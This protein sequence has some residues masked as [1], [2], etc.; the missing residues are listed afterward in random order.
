M[1][2]YWVLFTLISSLFAAGCNNIENS[3]I[4]GKDGSVTSTIEEEQQ[5]TVNEE[6]VAVDD[7]WK[8]NIA[9]TALF[10]GCGSI[11]VYAADGTPMTLTLNDASMID[12]SKL[13][14]L[15]GK[16]V[17][18][19]PFIGDD[20]VLE[21]IAFYTA[22]GELIAQGTPNSVMDKLLKERDAELGEMLDNAVRIEGTVKMSDL[23]CDDTCYVL[24]DVVAV[25][26]VNDTGDYY[27]VKEISRG[28]TSINVQ[29]EYS[30]PTALDGQCGQYDIGP[31]W[32]T[33]LD[34]NG[35][36]VVATEYDV[37]Y[38]FEKVAAHEVAS[39]LT[40]DNAVLVSKCPA[41]GNI[42]TFAR[43]CIYNDTA[44][45]FTLTYTSSDDEV[46][47][48]TLEPDEVRTFEWTSIQSMTVA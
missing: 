15:S 4:P 9:H 26:L 41:E 2:K 34:E 44:A 47:V 31:V 37:Y 38:I 48:I 14:S 35:D 16:G 20:N 8:L 6:K 30:Y 27:R 46:H 21:G 45:P 17:Y 32:H 22:T 19:I 36:P 43:D 1:K 33:T 18:Y 24:N 39:T 28:A 12:G 13:R 7:L 5:Y 42:E 23:R 29:S 10:N 11:G 3:V 40:E 25:Q